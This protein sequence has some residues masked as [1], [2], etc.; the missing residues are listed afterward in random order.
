MNELLIYGDINSY[1]ASEFITGFNEIEGD[2]LVVRVNSNGGDP[3]MAF[4]MAA[5]IAEFSGNKTLKVDG[6]AYSSACFML[7]Y[8]N[9]VECLDV[10]DFLFHR[11][12]YDTWFENS[13]YFTDEMRAMLENVNKSLESAMRK[14]LDVAKF[15]EITGVKIKDLFSM[16]SRIDVVLNAKQAKKVGLVDKIITLTADLSTNL[17]A[18]FLNMAAKYTGIPNVPIVAKSEPVQSSNYNKTNM[19]IEQL[20]SEHPNLVAQITESAVAVERDRTGA[21]LKFID[22]DPKAVAQGIE[23]GHNLGQTAMA[24]FS[25]KMMS[26]KALEGVE[27]DNPQPVDT[28]EIDGVETVEKTPA[29]EMH[30]AV[31]A[32]LGINTQKV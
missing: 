31:F 5:K 6:K 30:A 8:A 19:T 2:S 25:M 15:E 11:A 28:K 27:K 7:L 9:N 22:A 23:S 14:K 4:G 10:S 20:R 16:E 24:D 13:E 12:A 18:S 1:S 29:Q 21:W 32:G 26:A 3:Q 17:N